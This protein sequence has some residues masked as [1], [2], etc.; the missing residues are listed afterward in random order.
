M[1]DEENEKLKQVI[2]DM[3]R[4]HKYEKM[5]EFEKMLKDK[6]TEHKLL[7]EESKR[8]HDDQLLKEKE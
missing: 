7:L 5:E 8:R 3:I 2:A 1:K 6:E 4:K